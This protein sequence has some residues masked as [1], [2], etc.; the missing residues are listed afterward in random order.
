MTKL[1]TDKSVRRQVR[2][3]VPHGVNEN[4][5]VTVYGDGRI[6]LREAGRLLY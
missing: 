6:G 1:E 2:A 3:H 4:L 5:A